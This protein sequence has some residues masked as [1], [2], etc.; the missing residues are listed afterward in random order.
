MGKPTKS[1]LD[2]AVLA[3]IKMRESNQDPDFVAKALLNLN[4]RIQK[5]ERVQTAAKRYLHAGQSISDHH[6]LLQAIQSADDAS[7]ENS[8]EAD[9]PILGHRR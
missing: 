1:E 6:H 4:Y 2:Q 5:L 3:A 8:D 9:L 7:A